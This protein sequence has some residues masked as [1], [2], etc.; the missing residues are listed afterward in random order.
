MRAYVCV[1]M[2]SC[3]CC[4]LSYIPASASH[5]IKQTLLFPLEHKWQQQWRHHKTN[6][7]KLHLMDLFS[8][9]N[10]P[11]PSPPP[12]LDS[13]ADNVIEAGAGGGGGG[14][15]KRIFVGLTSWAAS[16]LTALFSSASFGLSQSGR[17]LVHCPV[18]CRCADQYKCSS[19]CQPT[20]LCAFLFI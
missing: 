1:R 19:A 10:V 12:P 11:P 18:G 13:F 4:T 9:N 17:A 16:A 14:S 15:E 8:N 2:C 7:V 5:F 3:V 6:E 20:V